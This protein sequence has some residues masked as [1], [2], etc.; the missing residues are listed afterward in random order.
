[1]VGSQSDCEPARVVDYGVEEGSPLRLAWAERDDV[2]ELIDDEHG[3]GLVGR[4]RI[5]E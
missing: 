1:M 5:F 4:A 3:I 2:L